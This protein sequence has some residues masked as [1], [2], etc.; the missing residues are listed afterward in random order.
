MD[1]TEDLIPFQVR[2]SDARHSTVSYIIHYDSQCTR[3]FL[4]EGFIYNR[5]NLNTC[6][7][8]SP[9]TDQ[10]TE[11]E[12]KVHRKTRLFVAEYGEVEIAG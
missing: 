8:F 5:E 1:I 10:D 7:K 9:A 2:I 4:Q 6:K 11:I 3:L 12:S